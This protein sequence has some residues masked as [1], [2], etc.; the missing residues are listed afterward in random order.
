MMPTREGVGREGARAAAARVDDGEPP[1]DGIP[2]RTR[3]E[4][5][6]VLLPD[7]ST[8]S[9][10][11]YQAVNVG[12]D[13]HLRE[14]TLA[15]AL[16]RFETGEELAIAFVYHDPGLR[17]L[18]LVIPEAL[19]HEELRERARLLT[20][21]AE[22]T[23]HA[24]PRYAREFGVVVGVAELALWLEKADGDG[25]M[26]AAREEAL[27]AREQELRDVEESA[28]KKVADSEVERETVRRREETLEKR[29]QQ[30]AQ[31]ESRLQ[32]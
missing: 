26:R 23:R 27:S 6:H 7:G 16:H 12:T 30:L 13:P 19:R 10:E 25:R 8:R 20:R 31:R 24:V 14:P 5:I 3:L 9:L 22:D 1:Y 17:R 21:I 11:V 4:P 15:G 32:A 29:E 2:G 28:R 18:A